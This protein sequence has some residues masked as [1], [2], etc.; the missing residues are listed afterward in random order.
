MFNIWLQDAKGSFSEEA[1]ELFEK[2]HGIETNNLKY[3][4]QLS[5]KN[6]TSNIHVKK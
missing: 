2:N 5:T 1:A 6:N 3:S 4:L